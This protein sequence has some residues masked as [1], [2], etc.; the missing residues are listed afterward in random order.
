MTSA[1]AETFGVSEADCPLIRMDTA[2]LNI[3][4]PAETAKWFRRVGRNLGNGNDAYRNVDEAQ[5]GEP[6]TPLET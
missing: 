1:E 3:A 6:W 2:K 4:P 5:T